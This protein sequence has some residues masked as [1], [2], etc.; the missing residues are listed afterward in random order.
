ALD[1]SYRADFICYGE[2]IIE[3]KALTKLMDAHLK[4]V[5]HYLKSTGLKRALLLN[6]GASKLEY[7]RV[8]SDY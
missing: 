2:I 7:R 8:V 1:A 3:L 6:F 5:I 4:Q